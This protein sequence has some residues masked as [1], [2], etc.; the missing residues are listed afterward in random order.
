MQKIDA[1]NLEI[2]MHP[3]FQ[4]VAWLKGSLLIEMVFLYCGT[5]GMRRIRVAAAGTCPDP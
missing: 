3:P 1:R 4:S 5:L 2:C